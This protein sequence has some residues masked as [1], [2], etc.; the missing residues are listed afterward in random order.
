MALIV[1]IMGAED[2]PD[3][4]T[5][6]TYR[7]MADILDVNFTREEDG[8]A[9]LSVMYP[10]GND[11]VGDLSSPHLETEK[12]AVFGNVYVMNENGKTISQFGCA[13]IPAI[14]NVPPK[15]MV[16]VKLDGFPLEVQSGYYDGRQLRQLLK[17]DPESPLFVW[18]Y[19]G[20]KH[21]AL[22]D[23]IG[24]G[25]ELTVANGCVFATRKKPTT[26]RVKPASVQAVRD[27]AARDMDAK[28]AHP[29]TTKN[30]AGYAVEEA[31]GGEDTFVVGADFDSALTNGK[32]YR[33]L[34]EMLD[35]MLR[36]GCIKYLEGREPVG[37][38]H[39][40]NAYAMDTL[41]GLRNLGIA[42]PKLAAEFL[43]SYVNSRKQ[44][45]WSV[46]EL[47]HLADAV[48]AE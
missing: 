16:T 36:Q 45:Q 43:Y 32:H 29:D 10:L 39:V 28:R 4:D 1:K 3:Q 44:P 7:L 34:G 30:A 42:T 26:V 31:K 11:S 5:R 47:Q 46:G 21:K 14:H 9:Y 25:T 48:W 41:R 27:I 33:D 13:R 22:W 38:V 2:A 40:G 12:F 18:T 23:D 17:L 6:K 20:D 24:K 35:D 19:N 37:V 15:P 8:Q